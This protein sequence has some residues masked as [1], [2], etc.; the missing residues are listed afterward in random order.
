[1]AR[2]PRQEC[3]GGIFH[4]FARGNA[5]GAIFHDDADRIAYL[6]LLGRVA[7]HRRWVLHAHCLMHN[8]VHLLI[9]TPQP[10]L[11]RGMQDLHGCYGRDFNDRH[12]RSGHVFQGRYGAVLIEDDDHF[13]LVKAY[14]ALNP[15]TAGL[16]E[17]PEDWPWTGGV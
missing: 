2:K 5:K 7:K 12:G 14:I 10:N 16:C 9:E 17:R 8:H 4:V 3:E 11:G 1:M 13:E 6:R 15:V